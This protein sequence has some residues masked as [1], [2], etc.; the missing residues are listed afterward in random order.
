[1]KGS[2][3][4]I[5]VVGAL[6]VVLGIMTTAVSYSVTLY[7]LFCAATGFGGATQRVAADA[8]TRSP[9][10][11]T[12]RFNADVAPDMP[13]RFFPIQPEVKVHL[14][15][16]KLVYFR[17][18]NLSDKAVVGHATYNVTPTKSGA[19]FDKI[20][21]FCFTEERL[22]AHKSVDMPVDFFVDP[23]IAGNPDTAE[24]DT[25]TLSYTFF[26]SVTPDKAQDLSRFAVGPADP[27][28]GESLFA[29]RCA[30]CHS[31]TENKIG[32]MLGGVFNR[33]AGTVSGY[34]YSAA[35]KDRDMLWTAQ[36]LDAWLTN[37]RAFIPGT[38]MPLA[39][40]ERGERADIIAY[41][42]QVGAAAAAPRAS[43]GPSA[44]K[45]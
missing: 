32:P 24:V 34:P 12:V 10:L 17:A 35:V 36:N 44:P 13:W 16:E 19:Y 27:A 39:I 23:D 3:R 2:W 25:I 21:C 9:R 26:P 45:S 41:L 43:A 15:E 42:K 40:A 7:R 8:A 1:M 31:L 14:G 37:P 5:A 11:V 29:E 33:R 18:E 30:A 28:L 4:N 38:R 20:Q 22:E 6:C